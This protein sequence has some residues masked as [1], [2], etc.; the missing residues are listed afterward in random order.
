[1][2]QNLLRFSGG[3]STERKSVLLADMIRWMLELKG[4]QLRRDSIEI[5]TEIATTRPILGD[6]VQIQQVLLNLVQNAHQAL[7]GHAGSRKLTMRLSD[8]DD[9]QVRLEVLDSGPGIHPN[10]LPRIFEAFTT[11][12]GPGE[13]N[14]LGLWVSYSIVEQHQGSLRAHNRPEGGAAFVIDLPAVS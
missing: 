8:L 13:G 14:G 5:V 2:L 12:K 4:H 7:V 3:H 6:E 9:K 10:V 1:M 11:T